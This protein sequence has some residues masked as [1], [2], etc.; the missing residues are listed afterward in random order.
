MKLVSMLFNFVRLTAK[1]Y[2]IDESHGISHSMDVFLK[3]NEIYNHEVL[4]SPFLLNQKRIIYTAAI[5]H[6]TCDRKYMDKDEGVSRITEFLKDKFST[7]DI[8][9]IIQIISTMS[10]SYVKKNG[11]PDLKEYQLAY[12]IVREAD[13]LAAYDINRSI[14]YDMEVNESELI[15][16]LSNSEEL[17]K[18]RMF[19]HFDD[20]LFITEYSKNIAKIFELESYYKLSQWKDI[21]NRF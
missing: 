15:T 7:R 1:T 11:F 13:L 9:I 20:D 3:S 17:F 6:D 18:K 19:K 5:L 2:E 12:H 8:D 14:I 4:K 16:S 21:I 10:Y